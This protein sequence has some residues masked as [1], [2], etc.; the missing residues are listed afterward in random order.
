MRA[1]ENIGIT[2]TSFPSY[3][4]IKPS[5]TTLPLSSTCGKANVRLLVTNSIPHNPSSLFHV[6][7]VPRPTKMRFRTAL[8]VGLLIQTTK[9]TL[10]TFP[11][12]GITLPRNTRLFY[13]SPIL[14]RNVFGTGTLS[15]LAE[16]S[17]LDTNR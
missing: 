8:H 16:K 9:G 7:P 14:Y 2:G 1:N 17:R 13:L 5:S 11:N 3:P 4:N 12:A 6:I 10:H 15:G